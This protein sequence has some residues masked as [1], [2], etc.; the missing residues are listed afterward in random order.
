MLNGEKYILGW[1]PESILLNQ[2]ETLWP[3]VIQALLAIH[4]QFSHWTSCPYANTHRPELY[5]IIQNP[6]Q[7]LDVLQTV[8]TDAEVEDAENGR[9]YWLIAPGQGAKFWAE[10]QAEGRQGTLYY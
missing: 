2:A 9:E 7:R 3:F 1:L 6:N 8:A 5:S 4:Q 10:W